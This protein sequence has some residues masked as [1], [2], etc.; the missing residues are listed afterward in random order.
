M[1][2]VHAR[3]GRARCWP[4]TRSSS[5]SWPRRAATSS[6]SSSPSPPASGS[7]SWRRTHDQR[8]PRRADQDAVDARG[9][10]DLRPG[11]PADRPDLR[12]RAGGRGRLPGPHLLLR[13]DA[14]PAA[15]AARGRLLRHRDPGPDHGRAVRHR[16]VPAQDD[17]DDA[18]ADPGAHPRA[19]GQGGRRRAVV[20]LHRAAHA[21]GGGRRRP[22]LERRA[23]RR[24]LEGD[25][26]GRRRGPRPAW[27]RPSC[28]GSS[29]SA[30]APWSRTRWRP[31]CSPSAA[32]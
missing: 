13:A 15:R 19:G 4:R 11:L 2:G 3:A 20:D 26:P 22:A 23:R 24:D 1:D 18:R 14:A 6:P 17:H 28:S 8:H 12:R 5:T 10:G 25:R 16:R 9:V 32:R 7:A 29:G 30:S 27:P 21:G 31:S